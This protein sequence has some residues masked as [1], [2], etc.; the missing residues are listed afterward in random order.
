MQCTGLA[1]SASDTSELRGASEREKFL[2]LS[3]VGRDEAALAH[4]SQQFNSIQFFNS[5]L[6]I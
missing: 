2:G 1:D 4:P 5:V 3:V 6:F